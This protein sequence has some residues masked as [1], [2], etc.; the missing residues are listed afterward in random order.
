MRTIHYRVD[1]LRNGVPYEQLMFST[2]P[3]VYSD[4]TAQIKLSMRG[5]FLR[6]ERVDYITDELR[7]VMIANGEEHPLGTYVIVTRRENGS[8]AGTVTDDIEAYDR[9]IRL[10]WAKLEHRDFWAAGTPYETVI[11]HYLTAAGIKNAMFTPT[12]NVLQSDR[13]DWDI[14]TDYLTIINTLLKEI[15]YNEIW[16][17]LSGAAQIAPYV[18]P[19]AANIRHRYGQGDGLKVLRPEY[20]SEIDLY[21]KPNVFIAILENP[22]Y[23]TPMVKYAVN[24]TPGSRL[25]TV[26]RGIRIP[27]VYKVDNIASEDEL[28]AYINR[29]RDEA[30][31]TSEYADIQ[32]ANMPGHEV[33]DVIALTHP[34]LIGIFREVSWTL[35][36]QVGAY[37]THQLQRV[38]VI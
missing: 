8:V 18:A 33:F 36:M 35:T 4:S 20:G 19:S 23:E 7:P 29:I 5:N 3:T 13:E 14:G 15:N 37:M 12:T 10:Q 2:A 24:D 27:Q 25:S 9:S 32:T 1:V 38:V 6:N 11:S 26:S 30:M 16:F 34:K 17:D 21:S 28:Q 22:E 31:Q